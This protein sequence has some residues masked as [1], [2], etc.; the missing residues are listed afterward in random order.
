MGTFSYSALIDNK[1]ET[2]FF[3]RDSLFEIELFDN[4]ID[5]ST[6]RWVN[7]C[8][9]VLT[10]LNP[11]AYNERKPIRIKILTTGSNQYTF[12]YSQ[13]GDDKNVVRGMVY[14]ISDSINSNDLFDDKNF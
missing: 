6:I 2:S 3:I 13:V 11:R 5:S 14:K 10:K 1:I 12:E 4:M 9:F 8:E 7:D